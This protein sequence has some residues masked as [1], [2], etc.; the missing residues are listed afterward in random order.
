MTA[1]GEYTQA[2]EAQIAHPL[3]VA[4]PCPKFGSEFGRVFAFLNYEHIC[5]EFVEQMTFAAQGTVAVPCNNP[6][7]MN[8]PTAKKR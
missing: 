3:E 6:H 5:V 7:A 4:R 1:T 8:Q 2:L